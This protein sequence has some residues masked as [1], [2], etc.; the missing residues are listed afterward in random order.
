MPTLSAVRPPCVVS[1]RQRL[2]SLKL[3]YNDTED[4]NEVVDQAESIIFGIS[5]RN[6]NRDLRAIR[7]AI[8]TY[9]DRIEYLSQHQ[10]DIVGL[11]TG[12]KDLDKLLGGLQRSDLIILAG[13]PGMGKSSMGLSITLQ[14]ARKWQ[15]RIALFTLEMSDEQLVQRLLSAETGI[16]SQRLR[17]GQIRDDEW[18]VLMQATGLLADTSI[19][20]DDTPA[21]SVME[22]RSKAAPPRCR[23]RRILFSVNC[24]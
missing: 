19:F 9:Y 3:A 7:H 12:L 5:A 8:D 24:G 6:E 2:R 10:N 20:I 14:A 21:I 23:T 1:L 15:K 17:L 22:L 13:R 11:P 18:P 16:D 4:V